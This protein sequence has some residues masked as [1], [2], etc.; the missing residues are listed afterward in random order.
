M[1]LILK[2]S[3]LFIVSLCSIQLSA[4]SNEFDK[5]WNQVDSLQD[6]GLYRMAQKEV[7]KI[8]NLGSE[9][10]DHNQVIKAVLY[11]LKFNSYLEEDDYVLGISKLDSLVETHH[12]PQKKF[13]TP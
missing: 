1:K 9:K 5:K 6:K 4:Q 8:F 7:S 10:G 3:L 13:Y 12:L 11:E 2:I